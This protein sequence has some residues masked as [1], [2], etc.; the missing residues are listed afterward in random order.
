M[1]TITSLI[2]DHLDSVVALCREDFLLPLLLH[3][4]FIEV[5]AKSKLEVSMII[6]DC[7]LLKMYRSQHFYRQVILFSLFV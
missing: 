5:S 7:F 1:P 2:L 3:V 4:S 6:G